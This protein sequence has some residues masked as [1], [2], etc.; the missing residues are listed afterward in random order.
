M[1]CSPVPT[2][3][4][5]GGSQTSSGKPASRCRQE[6]SLGTSGNAVF[7]TARPTRRYAAVKRK[8]ASARQKPVGSSSLNEGTQQT[9]SCGPWD[10][11]PRAFSCA[12]GTFPLGIHRRNDCSV[13]KDCR[14][15][16]ELSPVAAVGSSPVVQFFHG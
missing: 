13:L 12:D 2:S 16:V 14:H 11:F 15:R 10:A 1:R 7:G 8:G 9:R 5:I 4:V 6:T 3:G